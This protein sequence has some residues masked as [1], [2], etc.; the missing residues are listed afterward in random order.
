MNSYQ[1]GGKFAGLTVR[2]RDLKGC[3]LFGDA[4]H[5]C[6]IIAVGFKPVSY[7]VL[8]TGGGILIVTVQKQH[9]VLR[10]GIGK[11]KLCA[12]NI[13]ERLEGFKMLRSY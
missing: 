7:T 13:V 5:F 3:A 1:L 2:S 11:L 6:F 4:Y 10:E 12:D 8:S 9:T